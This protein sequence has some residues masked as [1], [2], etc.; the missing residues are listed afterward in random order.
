MLM[1]RRVLD[2]QLGVGAAAR[3]GND[4]LRRGQR[5]PR[6][7]RL[8]A[9]RHAAQQLHGRRQQL[10]QGHAIDEHAHADALKRHAQHVPPRPPR[11]QQRR[12]GVER[13]PQH[14]DGRADDAR[15]GLAARQRSG[16]EAPQQA[17]ADV[18]GKERDEVVVARHVPQAQEQVGKLVRV[19]AARA[20]VRRRR[21]CCFGVVQHAAHGGVPR[22][23]G[24]QPVLGREPQKRRRRVSS[25]SSLNDDVDETLDVDVDVDAAAAAAVADDDPGSCISRCRPII[26][27]MCI[28]AWV[29]IAEMAGRVHRNERD[30]GRKVGLAGI[31]R[32]GD[33]SAADGASGRT[34]TTTTITTPSPRQS[35]RKRLWVQK[36]KERVHGGKIDGAQRLALG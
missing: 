16:R 22:G 21:R 17:E 19:E 3:R 18:G 31:E 30:D 32:G 4:L 11:G 5:L 20:R 2:G 7:V 26:S 12:D 15:A 25:S 29:A 36:G 28:A 1:L 34:T 14:R 33:G 10:E 35:S 24:R 6:H 27:A 13:A 9:I 23:H 8:E